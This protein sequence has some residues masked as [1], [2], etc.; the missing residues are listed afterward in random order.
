MGN[1]EKLENDDNLNKKNQVKKV[2]IIKS[3]YGD[4]SLLKDFYNFLKKKRYSGSFW[5]G[6]S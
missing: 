3:G 2:R 1:S 6:R 4:E 5:S